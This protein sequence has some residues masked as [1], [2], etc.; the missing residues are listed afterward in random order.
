MGYATELVTENRNND[1]I[2]AFYNNL[3][4]GV[5]CRLLLRHQGD[6][7]LDKSKLH[8]EVDNIYIIGFVNEGWD[9]IIFENAFSA[10][11]DAEGVKSRP[12]HSYS[13]GYA[14]V[15]RE[16]T[17][18]KIRSSGCDSVL[19]TRVVDQRTKAIFTTKGRSSNYSAKKFNGKETDYS[20]FPYDSL[21]I[22]SN[23]SGIRITPKSSPTGTSFIIVTVE[24][25]LYD[26]QTETLIWSTRMETSLD[27]NKQEMMQKLAE[28]TV[29]NLK[30]DGL[31]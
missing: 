9:R 14:E 21:R 26:Q 19:L 27:S 24:S 8:G 4:P 11:L 25:L 16:T 17:F 15:E 12:S 5:P 1:C 18:D 10:Q 29:R 30:V 22:N 23:S 2:Q 13:P 20:L 31:I 7:F 6:R 28:E 3:F